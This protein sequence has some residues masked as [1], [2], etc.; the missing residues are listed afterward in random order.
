MCIPFKSMR[1]GI[2]KQ[3]LSIKYFSLLC[4]V[5]KI[6]C[7]LLHDKIGF[8]LKFIVKM[9]TFFYSEYDK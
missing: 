5:L 9:N 3:Q 7:E 4:F 6:F 2:I 1:R 8:M